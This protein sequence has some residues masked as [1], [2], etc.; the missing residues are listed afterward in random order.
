MIY[1]TVRT[2]VEGDISVRKTRT[3][4]AGLL[5]VN[6]SIFHLCVI[7]DPSRSMVCLVAWCCESVQNEV[8]FFGYIMRDTRSNNTGSLYTT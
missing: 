2:T 3:T 4:V 8:G 6:S 7:G 1:S 5:H